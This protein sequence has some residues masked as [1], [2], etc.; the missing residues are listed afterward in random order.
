MKESGV[1]DPTFSNYRDSNCGLGGNETVVTQYVDCG[2]GREEGGK[3]GANVTFWRME[4][5]THVPALS[6]KAQDEMMTFLLGPPS[7]MANEKGGGMKEGGEEPGAEQ[8]QDE[9]KMKKKRKEK[10][11]V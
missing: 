11:R 5:A 7:A 2:I 8:Q 9:E 3:G 4:G 6:P 10:L 1:K